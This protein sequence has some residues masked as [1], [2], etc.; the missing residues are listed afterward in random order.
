MQVMPSL[1]DTVNDKIDLVLELESIRHRYFIPLETR[2]RDD[3]YEAA[4]RRRM[5]EFGAIRAVFSTVDGP[6]LD[7]YIAES[8][9][10]QRKRRAGIL[11][12]AIGMLAA[13]WMVL[14]AAVTQNTSL[15]IASMAGWALAAAGIHLAFSS[16]D[17]YLK[18]ARHIA[19]ARRQA[20]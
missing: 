8:R 11:L 14:V 7:R 3:R 13:I 1:A 16:A 17:A 15:A 9:V 5:D 6:L 2:L 19:A 12:T 18:L 4:A 10:V 20:S